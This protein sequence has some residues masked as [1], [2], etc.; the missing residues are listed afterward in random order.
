MLDMRLRLVELM[1]EHEPPLTT[2]YALAKASGGAIPVTTAHR[3]LN[4][5][6]PP[7][8]VDFKTLDAICDTLK[9]KPSE[10]LAR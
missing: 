2:A 5:K 1:R 10:L 4:E 6:R 9:C 7:A 8:R 3:L